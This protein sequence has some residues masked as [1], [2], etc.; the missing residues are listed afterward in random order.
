MM[1]TTYLITL[2]A[3]TFAA[4]AI[5]GCASGATGNGRGTRR[6]AMLRSVERRRGAS[7]ENEL[8]GCRLSFAADAK[9]IQT[10][11]EEEKPAENRR[12]TR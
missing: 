9:Q 6:W 7:D 8:F 10:F 12:R 3:Y 4:A 5:Y 1:A 2:G 11:K